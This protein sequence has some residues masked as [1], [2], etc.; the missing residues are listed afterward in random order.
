MTVAADWARGDKVGY[1]RRDARRLE[2]E[3]GE[4]TGRI[5]VYAPI[6]LRVGRFIE[7]TVESV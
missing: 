1:K 6:R 3:L 4:F 2:G 5:A 7:S